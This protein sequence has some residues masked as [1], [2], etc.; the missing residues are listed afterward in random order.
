MDKKYVI[1]C[2][3]RGLYHQKASEGK[4]AHSSVSEER[5]C[6]TTMDRRMANSYLSR[7]EYLQVMK[8]QY[9]VCHRHFDE[10][11]YQQKRNGAF[12]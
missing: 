4:C 2:T 5:R 11:Y 1:K 10:Q 7:F 3:V 12:H 6:W 8:R 9:F